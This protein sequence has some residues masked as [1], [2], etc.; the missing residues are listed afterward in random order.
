MIWET[1]GRTAWR[2]AKWLNGNHWLLTLH[3]T[4][5]K[6]RDALKAGREQTLR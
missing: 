3:G 5:G 1:R 6:R 4:A 2:R